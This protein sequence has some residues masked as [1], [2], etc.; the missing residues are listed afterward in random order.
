MWIS[1]TKSNRESVHQ[2]EPS[3]NS[4][5][6]SWRGGTK[7]EVPNGTFKKIFKKEIG[8]LSLKVEGYYTNITQLLV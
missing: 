5:H 2:D 8:P 1:L 7:V 6:D 4:L 3:Y